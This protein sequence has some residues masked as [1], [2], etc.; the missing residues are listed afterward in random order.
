MCEYKIHNIKMTKG[1][2]PVPIPL[3]LFGDEG[4]LSRSHQLT[5]L[6]CLWTV[7]KSLNTYCA[8]SYVLYAQ[9]NH[10]NSPKRPLPCQFQTRTRNHLSFW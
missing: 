5:T 9:I 6:A 4:S 1:M 10:E 3:V 8:I 7:G 2:H